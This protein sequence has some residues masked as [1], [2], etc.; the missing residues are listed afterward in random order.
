MEVV[1]PSVSI[2]T[3]N[4][5]ELKTKLIEVLSSHLEKIEGSQL[6]ELAESVTPQKFMSLI[7]VINDMNYTINTV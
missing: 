2:L 3:F 7:T 6:D 1:A 5:I 4:A